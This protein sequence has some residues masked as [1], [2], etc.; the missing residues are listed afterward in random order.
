MA[1]NAVNH[2]EAAREFHRLNEAAA[3]QDK[4]ALGK[5]RKGL[6]A[7]LLTDSNEMLTLRPPRPHDDPTVSELDPEDHRSEERRPNK[8]VKGKRVRKSTKVR[9]PKIHNSKS[10]KRPQRFATGDSGYK[11]KSPWQRFHQE[12]LQPLKPVPQKTSEKTRAMIRRD[13]SA[14]HSEEKGM[15]CFGLPEPETHYPI[16]PDKKSADVPSRN[17][18]HEVAYTRNTRPISS[19]SN[20]SG[21]EPRRRRNFTELKEQSQRINSGKRL[22]SRNKEQCSS[23]IAENLQWLGEKDEPLVQRRRYSR[24]TLED[25]GGSLGEVLGPSNSNNVNNG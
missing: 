15:F 3:V 2:F 13:R 19:S 11:V 23:Q 18:K 4:K 24:H 6:E 7:R 21:T 5:W 16:V 9:P 12:K 20:S 10:K 25:F 8:E 1:I 22:Q 14:A 17:V